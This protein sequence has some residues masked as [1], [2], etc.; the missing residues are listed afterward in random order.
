M[1]IN[2][3]Y[4]DAQLKDKVVLDDLEFRHMTQVVRVR[5]GETVELFNGKGDLAKAVL[6]AIEKKQA[7]LSIFET[8]HEEKPIP[9]ILAQ[10]LPRINRLDFLIEK[11]TELGMTELWLFPGELSERKSLTEHQIERLVHLT[12]AACKQSGRLWLP[13]IKWLDGI[14]KW[15]TPINGV[16]GDPD[17][18]TSLLALDKHP[19]VIVIGPESGFTASETQHLA[20]LGATPCIWNDAVLRTDTAAISGVAI[21][22][23]GK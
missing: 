22:Q 9:L 8:I 17:A 15:K 21:I 19:E 20:S 12:I 2:R 5:E 6:V 14:S 16:F 1:P 10:A 13:A 23:A 11:C 18:R 3:F 4:L 7:R